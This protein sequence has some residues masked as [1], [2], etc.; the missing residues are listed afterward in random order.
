VD[1]LNDFALKNEIVKKEYE[2]ERLENSY[3]KTQNQELMAENQNFLQEIKN[4][5]D[6]ISSF[7][8]LIDNMPKGDEATENNIRDYLLYL[9][10]AL[11]EHKKRQNEMF[12]EIKQK[13]EI[14][15]EERDKYRR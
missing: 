10:S 8:E 13:D 12:A 7:H 6:K 5:N 2:M 4:L 14:I 1:V 11:S 9:Q 15:N 3:L